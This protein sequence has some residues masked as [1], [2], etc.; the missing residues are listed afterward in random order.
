MKFCD[1]CKMKFND[2]LEFI[3]HKKTFVHKYKRMDPAEKD[4]IVARVEARLAPYLLGHGVKET[5]TIVLVPRV[6]IIIERFAEHFAAANGLVGRPEP[7]WV[8]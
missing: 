2:V 1:R 7:N 6:D 4:R 5:P 8:G 3:H